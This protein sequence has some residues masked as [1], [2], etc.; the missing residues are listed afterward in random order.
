MEIVHYKSH[1]C[2]IQNSKTQS[3]IK[4]VH[5]ENLYVCIY[6]K[7]TKCADIRLYIQP[8]CVHICIPLNDKKCI[9]IKACVA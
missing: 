5:M 8:H 1:P 6:I 2:L 7:F 4:D 9:N 3:K